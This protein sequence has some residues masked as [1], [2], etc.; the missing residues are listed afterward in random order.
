MLLRFDVDASKLD[1]A[2]FDRPP[3]GL[4]VRTSLR[5]CQHLAREDE[6]SP[7]TFAE[8]VQPTDGREV[9]DGGVVQDEEDVS[10]G[11]PRNLGEVR[12]GGHVFGAWYAQPHPDGLQEIR[13]SAPFQPHHLGEAR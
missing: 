10:G 12:L 5:L 2:L 6:T 7:V 1:P 8:Y 9:G 13:R 4:G 11:H 3:N